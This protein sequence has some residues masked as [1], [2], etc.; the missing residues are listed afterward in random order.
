MQVE[1]IGRLNQRVCSLPPLLIGGVVKGVYD[2]LLLYNFRKV[3][4]PEE[5]SILP[6]DDRCDNAS[7]QASIGGPA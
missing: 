1:W 7:K 3:R 4:P 2:L 5:V 6:A